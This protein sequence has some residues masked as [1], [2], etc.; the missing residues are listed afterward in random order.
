MHHTFVVHPTGTRFNTSDLTNQGDKN[1]AFRNAH[2]HAARY[3]A[4]QQKPS[5]VT[6]LDRGNERFGFQPR[7]LMMP[8][9][10]IREIMDSGIN[11]YWDFRTNCW[12]PLPAEEI[13]T[14]EQ[15]FL[16]A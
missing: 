9:S 5:F 8:R 10:V 13:S 14:T 3:T 16:L 11:A 4:Q 2:W 12:L 15:Q 6:R 1:D 7:A